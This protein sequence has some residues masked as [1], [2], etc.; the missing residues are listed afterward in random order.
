MTQPLAEPLTQR[1]LQV[2]AL[3]AAGASNRDIADSLVISP[4]TVKKHTS[5]IF[6]KLAVASRTQ[7]LVRA[8]ELGLLPPA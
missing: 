1:E 5:N 8:T 2:L 7:A 3:I 6:G 4:N